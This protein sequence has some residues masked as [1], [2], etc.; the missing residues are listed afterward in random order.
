MAEAALQF[1]LVSNASSSSPLPYDACSVRLF[2]ADPKDLLMIT[3]DDEADSLSEEG[4]WR[5]VLGGGLS[6]IQESNVLYP[7]STSRLYAVQLDCAC[8]AD[9]SLDAW[10]HPQELRVGPSSL[11]GGLSSLT[12]N[13][14]P[15]RC[16]LPRPSRR[17]HHGSSST[18]STTSRVTAAT[19]AAATAAAAAAVGGL[20]MLAAFGAKAKAPKEADSDAVLG[21][22]RD[23]G[24]RRRLGLGELRGG[25]GG[26]DDT[27]DAD[28][29]EEIYT[30]L[31]FAFGAAG[32]IGGGGSSIGDGG[33][34]GD[35]DDDDHG[36]T[37]SGGAGGP[38]PGAGDNGEGGD[39][40]RGV[41]GGWGAGSGGRRFS[42]L[43]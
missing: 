13:V 26:G 2:E 30:S 15:E 20:V 41:V 25:G 19:A 32:S 36:G 43:S 3:A 28:P 23:V 14:N 8:P 21:M 11:T 12:F 1:S 40:T 31:A 39:P 29:A 16:I 34:G 7:L 10:V 27:E 24:L 17:R 42:L 18:I 4:T 37:A 33:S 5:L 35:D 9:P 38:P 22:S 6:M